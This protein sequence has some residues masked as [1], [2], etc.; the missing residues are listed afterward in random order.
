MKEKIKQI[1]KRFWVVIVEIVVVLWAIA[2][3]FDK[4]YTSCPY[5]DVDH[6]SSCESGYHVAPIII[7]FG[8]AAFILYLT[9]RWAK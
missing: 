3:A 9:R 8:T 2:S 6:L 4:Y 5:I 7:Y 1:I